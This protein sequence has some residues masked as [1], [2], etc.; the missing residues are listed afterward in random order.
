MKCV[1]CDGAENLSAFPSGPQDAV[2]L[3]QPLEERR[4]TL[5]D[6]LIVKQGFDLLFVQ[7]VQC[8]VK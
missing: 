4:A 2:T 3:V 6:D 5:A 7:R 1:S 8:L